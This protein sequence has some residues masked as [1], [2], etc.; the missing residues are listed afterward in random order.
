MIVFIPPENAR[1]GDPLRKPRDYRGKP[2]L[3]GRGGQHLTILLSF[4]IRHSGT[5]GVCR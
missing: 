3:G 1:S 4:L 2:K 5:E